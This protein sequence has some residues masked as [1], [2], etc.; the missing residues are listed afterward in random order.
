MFVKGNDWWQGPSSDGTVVIPPIWFLSCWVAAF[1]LEHPAIPHPEA[2]RCARCSGSTCPPVEAKS[3]PKKVSSSVEGSWCFPIL[4]GFSTMET[5][6]EDYIPN[7]IRFTNWCFNVWYSCAMG[8]LNWWC[9]SGKQQDPCDLAPVA[10][11]RIQSFRRELGAGGTPPGPIMA[12]LRRK[13]VQIDLLSPGKLAGSEDP[14]W[15]M[16]FFCWCLKRMCRLT[17]VSDRLRHDTD[18]MIYIYTHTC[19]NTH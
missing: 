18:T 10:A 15:E 9:F 3:S 13:V 5:F 4:G 1:S 8:P 12:L 19:H 6:Y 7:M 14:L 2:A 11:K 16:V 17:S